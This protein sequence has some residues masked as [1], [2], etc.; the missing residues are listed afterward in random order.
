MLRLREVFPTM[1]AMRVG[2][3]GVPGGETVPTRSDAVLIRGGGEDPYTPDAS[4]G[5][6]KGGRG[7]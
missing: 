4:R 7:S 3:R 1:T 5:E 6:R 2:V